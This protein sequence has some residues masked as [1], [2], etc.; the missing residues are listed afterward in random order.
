MASV[1]YNFIC[2][3]HTT[4]ALEPFMESGKVRHV[5]RITFANSAVRSSGHFFFGGSQ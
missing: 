1:V 5:Q 2:E 4:L 3:K